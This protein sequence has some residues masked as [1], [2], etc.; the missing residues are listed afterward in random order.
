MDETSHLIYS[1]YGRNGGNSALNGSGNSALNGSGNGGQ[2]C[3][4]DS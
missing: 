4:F 3:M 1:D 2:Q